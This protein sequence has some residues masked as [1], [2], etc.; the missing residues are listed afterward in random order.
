[1]H[2]FRKFRIFWEPLGSIGWKM[3]EC[4]RVQTDVRTFGKLL[5]LIKKYFLKAIQ[6]SRDLMHRDLTILN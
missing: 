4:I 3:T 5:L 2:N 6:S 1:M